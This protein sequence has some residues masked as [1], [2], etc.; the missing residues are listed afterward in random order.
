MVTQTLRWRHNGH[1]GISNHEPHHCLLNCLS[2]CRSKK[3]SKLRVT[4]LCGS[5]S[6]G[7]C[8]FPAQMASNAENVSIWWRHHGP[9]STLAQVMAWCLTAPSHYLNQSWLI[10]ISED[11][12]QSS[13]GSFIRDTAALDNWNH[14]ENSPIKNVIQ[15]SKRPM[16]DQLWMLKCSVAVPAVFSL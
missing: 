11:Q 9:G 5:N 15:I 10:I 3:T 7:T 4:G 14:L 6:P 16:K 12:W 13:E 2:R 1:D 8:E